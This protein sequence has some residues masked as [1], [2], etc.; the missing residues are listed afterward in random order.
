MW[1]SEED[2]DIR[3]NSNRNLLNRVQRESDYDEVSLEPQI[4]AAPEDCIDPAMQSQVEAAVRRP[5]R[6]TGPILTRQE[7]ADAVIVGKLAGKDLAAQLFQKQPDHIR[8]M[9]DKETQSHNGTE[10]TLT[11]LIEG[12]RTKIRDLAFDRLNTIMECLDETKIKS[13]TKARELSHIGVQVATIAEK[14]LPKEMQADQNV[15]FHMFRPPVKEESEYER[16]E[17]GEERPETKV[18]EGVVDEPKPTEAQHG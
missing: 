18:I 12:Q 10:Q 5:R 7:A 2:G 8:L 3:L 9:T 14:M 1:I 6:A 16:V 13:V 11:R 15:H 4:P 17:V